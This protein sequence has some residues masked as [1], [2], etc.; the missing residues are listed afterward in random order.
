VIFV[1]LMFI[2]LEI[3]VGAA[4]PI[5]TLLVFL[6]AIILIFIYAFFKT[7]AKNRRR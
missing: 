7:V 3:C 1:I 5:A 4:Y 6:V 2:I